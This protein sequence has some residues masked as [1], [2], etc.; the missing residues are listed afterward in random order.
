MKFKYYIPNTF[1]ALN[2]TCG[3]VSIT[4]I[5]DNDM[6]TGALFIFFAVVFDFLDGIAARLLDARSEFGKV[7]DSLADVVSFGAAPGIIIFKLLLFNCEGSCNFLDRYTLTPYFALLIPICAAMRLARFNIDSRQS[8]HFIGLPTPA[9]AIFFASVTLVIF[10]QD[11][12]ITL[13]PLHFLSTFLA[14]TRVLVI[15]T[16]FFAY[17]MISD[18]KMFSLKFASIGWKK[19]RLQY[20]FLMGS[21]LLLFIFSLS[22]LPMIIILYLILSLVFQKEI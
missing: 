3:L 17:L 11:R 8:D 13:I 20:F 21:L 22:A 1:T 19:N 16:V 9:N 10:L 6:L 7:L 4:R 12:F 14:S 2:L 15:L 5:M 18:F